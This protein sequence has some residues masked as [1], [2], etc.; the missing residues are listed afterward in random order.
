MVLAYFKSLYFVI[1]VKIFGKGMKPGN[2]GGTVYCILYTKNTFMTWEISTEI[3][4]K[5]QTDK[6]IRMS[7]HVADLY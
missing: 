4:W 7:I 2:I 6:S 5:S 1:C 3:V